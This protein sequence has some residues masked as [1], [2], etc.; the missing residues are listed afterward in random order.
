MSAECCGAQRQSRIRGWSR[1]HSELGLR[2]LEDE[3]I[4]MQGSLLYL[5]L[6]KQPS[7]DNCQ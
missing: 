4:D 2:N 5:G 6:Q 7:G 1:F 3:L